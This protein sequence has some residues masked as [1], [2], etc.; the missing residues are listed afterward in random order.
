MTG[1]NQGSH[2]GDVEFELYDTDSEGSI[3][4]VCYQ[5]GW[6]M[7]DDGY[8]RYGLLL[9]QPLKMPQIDHSF[10]DRSGLSLSAKTLS[11]RLEYSRVAGA[12]SRQRFNYGELKRLTYVG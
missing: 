4:S 8:L 7:V 3:V 5:G 6:L 10:V 9:F 11:V 2:L 12:S 1:I